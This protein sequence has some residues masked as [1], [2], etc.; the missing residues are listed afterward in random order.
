MLRIRTTSKQPYAKLVETNKYD[1]FALIH[2]FLKVALLLS[3]AT[4]DVCQNL[5]PRVSSVW[6]RPCSVVSRK[7]ILCNSISP[8]SASSSNKNLPYFQQN[9]ISVS[10]NQIDICDP[11]L[12]HTMVRHRFIS[13]NYLPRGEFVSHISKKLSVTNI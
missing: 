10:S 12:C 6:I 11:K 7:S 2:K 5:A 4:T 3:I 9:I 1:K 13:K 8:I